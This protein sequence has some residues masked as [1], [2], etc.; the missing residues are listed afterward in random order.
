MWW[1]VVVFRA[2]QGAVR[3]EL[4]LA[5]GLVYE[6]PLTPSSLHLL[7][8]QE[9][10]GHKLAWSTWAQIMKMV[11]PSWNKARNFIYFI[12]H[13]GS[14]AN[15]EDLSNTNPPNEGFS[16]PLHKPH[17]APWF[18]KPGRIKAKRRLA[19]ELSSRQLKPWTKEERRGF[20]NTSIISSMTGALRQLT[21]WDK[22][23]F[24]GGRRWEALPSLNLAIRGASNGINFVLVV[25]VI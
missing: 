19:F 11:W 22:A 18:G 10:W 23:W 7:T 4:Q 25:W 14:C 5:V 12:V 3:R 16:Q 13:F 2:H 21:Q 24:H 6:G 17:K 8:P 1:P 9:V 20:R 15:D